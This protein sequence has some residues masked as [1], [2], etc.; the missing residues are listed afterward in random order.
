MFSS[1]SRPEIRS[2][3]HRDRDEV[4][5]FATRDYAEGDVLVVDNTIAGG[6]PVGR[7]RNR[8]CWNCFSFSSKMKVREGVEVCTYCSLKCM[9]DDA[10][11]L[12]RYGEA[13][14]YIQQNNE[15][16][17]DAFSLVFRILYKSGSEQIEQLKQLCV[18]SSVNTQVEEEE[19]EMVNK[20]MKSNILSCD[21]DALELQH[22]LR[23]IRFNA[24]QLRLAL[25]LTDTYIIVVMPILSRLNHSCC[26]NTILTAVPKSGGKV[27]VEAVACTCIKAD[28]ELRISYLRDISMHVEMRAQL[29]KNFSFDCECMR[30]MSEVADMVPVSKQSIESVHEAADALSSLSSNISTS[31]LYAYQ[32]IALEHINREDG[33]AAIAQDQLSSRRLASYYILA[34]VSSNLGLRL[35]TLSRI[36]LLLAA[37]HCFL[38]TAVPSSV[39]VRDKQ[40]AQFMANEATDCLS[41][42]TKSCNKDKDDDSEKR[43]GILF[44]MLA[45]AQQFRKVLLSE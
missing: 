29:L 30:C 2:I 27:I 1:S 12:E 32:D 21:V 28:Q 6:V 36:E 40:R 34:Q 41:I 23:I 5:L 42:L 33:P 16:L 35:A 19:A 44:D 4:G 22:M 3:K 15:K 14:Q 8:V 31:M 39:T 37:C 13:I 9:Q 17:V 18:G 26:P 11:F 43:H 10:L 45:L 20:V 24:Q 25:K 38:K 7:H